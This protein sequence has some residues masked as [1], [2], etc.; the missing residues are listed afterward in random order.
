MRICKQCL[1]AIRSHGEKPIICDEYSVSEEE[2]IIC[3][4]CEEI[5]E[6]IIE[7]IL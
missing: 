7:I 3:E 6:E 4:W 2:A 5:T 1:E